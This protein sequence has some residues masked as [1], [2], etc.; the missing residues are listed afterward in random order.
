MISLETVVPFL[1]C[2]PVIVAVLMFITRNSK[3]RAIF[4]YVGAV[5]IIAAVGFLLVDWVTNGCRPVALF[6]ETETINHVILVAEIVLMFV[7][8]FLCFKYKKYW[9]SI[10]SIVPTCMIAYVDLRGPKL[11][12]MHHV[13]LDHLSILMCVIVGLIGSM[14]AI[15][16]VGYMDGYHKHHTEFKDRTYY[17]LTV[18]FLFLG[19]MFGFVTSSNLLWIDFFWELTSVCSFLLIGYTR[20]DEAINNSF[21]ALWMNL[22]GGT[23][24]AVGIVYAAYVAGTTDLQTLVALGVLKQ[25]VAVL[26][27]AMI[28]FAAL[29]KASQLPFST[30][31][32]GAMVAPTPSSALLH[33]ATMVKAGIYILFRLAPGM[34]GT[35]TGLMVSLVGG[36][37]FFIMSIFAVEQTD[38]KKVLAFSTLSN[39]GLMT[40]CAGVGVPATVWA[41]V[42]LMVFHAVSK[43]LLFQDIGAT[44]NSLHTRNIEDF[45]GLLHRLPKLASCMFIG[46]V[47]MFLAP[48]GML[49]SKW[50]T[51]KSVIDSKNIILVLLICFGS[52]TTTLYWSKWLGKLIQNPSE[53]K[54]VKDVTKTGEY[55]S[56]Y[57]H[58]VIMIAVTILIPTVSLIYVNPLVTELFGTSTDVMSKSVLYTMVA[59]L[60]LAFLVPFLAYL[61]TKNQPTKVDL[62]YMNGVNS[63]DN[64]GFVNAFGETTKMELG[65]YYFDDTIKTGKMMK[66]AQIALAV[67][68]VVMT[69]MAIVKGGAF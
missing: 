51:L 28:A 45:G 58:T 21:R 11:E 43:S 59:M 38:G 47:G 2:F 4:A 50:A 29:T 55:I 31:L 41:G 37:T 60:I 54:E 1:I 35:E 61:F 57:I 27:I 33:S 5:A 67:W 65:N 6:V 3:V 48:F 32:V 68:I 12:E 18:L 23:A 19:A 10:L 24:L 13:Y 36:F 25:P 44:E 46:I 56:L 26:P 14:I 20:T 34:S 62:T 63:G 39:L 22:F 15:Y 53:D 17:F 66:Y 30:W 9:I 7:V 49:F 8:T 64:K 40:A 16:A 52:A 69:A 42:F